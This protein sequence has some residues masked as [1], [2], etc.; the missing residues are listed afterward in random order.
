MIPPVFSGGIIG[1]HQAFGNVGIIARL[2]SNPFHSSFAGR[3]DVSIFYRHHFELRGD[4]GKVNT[5]DS[6]HFDES[7]VEESARPMPP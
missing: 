7:T 4:S 6:V 5:E 2:L 3:M 1:I